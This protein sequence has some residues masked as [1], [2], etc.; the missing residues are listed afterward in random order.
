ML[1]TAGVVREKWLETSHLI[2]D[3]KNQKNAYEFYK[4]EN[5]KHIE[6]DGLFSKSRV[7]TYE[8]YASYA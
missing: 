4:V 5:K 2:C 7:Q 3:A 6:K 8:H 1:E